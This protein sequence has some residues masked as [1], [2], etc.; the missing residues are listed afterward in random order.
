MAHGRG[1]RADFGTTPPKLRWG[2]GPSAGKRVAQAPAA[3]ATA[4]TSATSGR[5]ASGRAFGGHRDDRHDL[6]IAR[7]HR[8]PAAGQPG[9]I[10]PAAGRGHRHGKPAQLH[11]RFGPSRT[12]A[13]EHRKGH[14]G[15]GL[16]PRDP[17]IMTRRANVGQRHQRR[18]HVQAQI[19][20]DPARHMR[21]GPRG[22]PP[23]PSGGTAI[24]APSPP[25]TNG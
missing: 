2:T 3:L 22:R 25:N 8:I 19:I 20:L 1:L 9:Q 16:K 7:L 11:L 14:V 12:T 13:R 21:P 23:C 24:T 10:G 17:H 6:A 5:K 18:A 4:T 15:T